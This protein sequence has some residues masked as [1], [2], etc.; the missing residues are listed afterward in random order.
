MQADNAIRGAQPAEARKGRRGRAG[1]RFVG[2]PSIRPPGARNAA[3][4]SLC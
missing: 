2:A 3:A 4:C 1:E